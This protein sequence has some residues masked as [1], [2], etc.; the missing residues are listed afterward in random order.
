MA[1]RV[2]G[3]EPGVVLSCALL[4]DTACSAAS[5]AP[6]A[7]AVCR[8]PVESVRG[9]AAESG[10]GGWRRGGRSRPWSALWR[11]RRRSLHGAHPLPQL[12]HL[13]RPWPASIARIPAPEHTRS[14]TCACKSAS[15]RGSSPPLSRAPA[16]ADAAAGGGAPR[17]TAHPAGAKSAQP[18]GTPRAEE[19]GASTWRSI[20]RGGGLVVGSAG[21]V[22]RRGGGHAARGRRRRGVEKGEV[23]RGFVSDDR[24]GGTGAADFSGAELGKTAAEGGWSGKGLEERAAAGARAGARSACFEST[25]AGGCAQHKSEPD[26]MGWGAR[27]QE[28][29]G[30]AW[31]RRR[32]RLSFSSLACSSCP[33]SAFTRSCSAA[34]CLERS[35]AVS[36][37][38]GSV[39]LCESVLWTDASRTLLRIHACR[40]G[41]C[42][43]GG[44]L[45]VED[46][47]LHRAALICTVTAT[48]NVSLA[49]ANVCITSRHDTA[50]SQ[51]AHLSGSGLRDLE[52]IEQLLL[53]GRCL[54]ELLLR[55]L[56]PTIR[57]PCQCPSMPTHRLRR[58]PDQQDTVFPAHHLVRVGRQRAKLS[59][60]RSGSTRQ[61]AARLAPPARARSPPAPSP[62][63]LAPAPAPPCAS[64]PPAPPPEPSP[65]ACHPPAGSSA[66]TPPHT[67]VTIHSRS[68]KSKTRSNAHLLLAFCVLR[69]WISSVA[70]AAACVLSASLCFSFPTKSST[71][72]VAASK[73]RSSPRT[74]S[75]A[76]RSSSSLCR[77]ALKFSALHQRHTCSPRAS[78]A[79]GESWGREM[80]RADRPAGCGGRG[81]CLWRRVPCRARAAAPPSRRSA[82]APLRPPPASASAPSPP[83]TAPTRHQPLPNHRPP[84]ASP[85]ST[86]GPLHPRMERSD[87][88]VRGAE[89]FG[90]AVRLRG[91]GLESPLR[92]NRVVELSAA[93]I[94]DVSSAHALARA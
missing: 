11:G 91:C 20:A 73:S 65:A 77:P 86:F 83:A 79:R 8:C 84:P 70:S 5:F 24:R 23:S 56:P 28:R 71:R 42:G 55:Q 30:G 67:P 3:E 12:Q 90:D 52:R 17:S 53:P 60:A 37:L 68:D 1:L 58:G 32:R 29:G 76:T 61:P 9:E 89:V 72:P 35:K 51:E 64:P 10:R 82:A 41:A 44:L 50:I 85:P 6:D 88:C 63:L 34:I 62:A 31:S 38:R 2:G 19:T 87:L 92:R 36:A 48:A 45:F 40:H 14:I 94:S 49:L 75:C 7:L 78:L 26:M 43:G 39:S 27:R 22:R 59:R 81:W 25:S 21:R 18:N 54:V 80:R 93:T 33:C 16:P 4:G 13:R 74:R 57:V 69:L 66:W 46:I 47:L 15:R